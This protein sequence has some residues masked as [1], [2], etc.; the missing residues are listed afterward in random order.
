METTAKAQRVY[1]DG[2]VVDLDAS[3]SQ[4]WASSAP[5]VAS[6]EPQPDGTVK[7]TA[8]QPGSAIITVN[9][10]EASGEA[11]LEVTDARLLSLQVS[12]TIAS[13]PVG[14]TQQFTAQ[15][16][17]SDGTTVDVTSSATW[18]TSNTAIA[19]VSSTGLGTGVAA[20]GPVTL[21]ATLGG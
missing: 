5:Q 4:Q 2:R 19:T 17:Y 8:L 12:P 13:V 3:T 14:I 6:V 10:D 9:A 1:D 16:S 18:T 11:T 7:V 20:G 21:T 15:G